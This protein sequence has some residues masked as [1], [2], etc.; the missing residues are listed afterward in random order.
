MPIITFDAPPPAKDAPPPVKPA[1]IYVCTL[2]E[3]DSGDTCRW[4]GHKSGS[5]HA[6]ERR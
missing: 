2:D 4:C 1:P 3:K 6:K 5:G